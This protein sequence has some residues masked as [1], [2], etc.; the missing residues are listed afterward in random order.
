MRE[1]GGGGLGIVGGLGG[2]GYGDSRSGQGKILGH[3]QH[4]FKA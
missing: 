4:R 2:G 1:A 3:W